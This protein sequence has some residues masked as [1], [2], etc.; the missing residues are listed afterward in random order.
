YPERRAACFDSAK[1]LGVKTLR[2]VTME[3]LE[4]NKEKLT[5]VQ[6]RRTRHVV[7]EIKRTTDAVAA[8]EAGNYEL[9]GQLMYESHASMRDDFEITTREID[10]LVEEAQKIGLAGG[11][12]G[13]RMTGGGFGGCTVSLIRTSKMDSI[14]ET[15]RKNYKAQTGI[16]PDLFVTRPAA[17]ARILQK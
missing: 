10:I 6:Y 7:S 11:V 14:M 13:S 17:G 5:D 12:Y 1:I 15:I 2:E 9:V 3:Q 4:A 16:D 8:I